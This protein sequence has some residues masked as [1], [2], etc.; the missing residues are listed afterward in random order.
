[1]NRCGEASDTI[2]VYSVHDIF[3]PN[4]VTINDDD[5]NEKLI[6]AMKVGQPIYLNTIDSISGSLNVYDRWG[7]QIFSDANY[8]NNWPGANENLDE[9]IYYYSF[10]HLNCP[11]IKGWVQLIR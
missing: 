3:I 1:M 11:T 10:S 8:K 9:G 5:K 6:I 7:T 4:V 2:K